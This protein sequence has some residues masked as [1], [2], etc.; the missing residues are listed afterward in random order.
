MEFVAAHGFSLSLAAPYLRAA[1]IAWSG[2]GFRL[3]RLGGIELYATDPTLLNAVAPSERETGRAPFYLFDGQFSAGD[4]YFHTLL[5]VP[6]E[7]LRRRIDALLDN[8]RADDEIDAGE[9]VIGRFDDRRLELATDPLSQYP[10]YYFR[11]GERFII[12]NVLRQIA[13]VLAASELTVTPSLLPCLEG[14][15]FG[16]V[17][18]DSTHLDEVRR[19]PFGHMV[20]A[21]PRLRFHRRQTQDRDLTYE[22]IISHG[23]SALA[24]H[25]RAVA[26]AVPRPRL[27]ATDVT[28][29]S[30]LRLV[31]SLL[32]DSPL[33]N[34]IQGRCF[35]RY[36]N[37]DANVAGALMSKYNLP[38]AQVPFVID[39]D[40]RFWRQDLQRRMIETNAA[41]TGGA[42]V[43]VAPR[44]TIAF[45]NFVHFS[46][47]F[48]EIGGAFPSVDFVGE[49]EREEYS[50]A[51]A[52][53]LI[54]AHRRQARALDLVSNEGIAVVC[55][56]AINALIALEEEGIPREHLPA[57]FYLR[58]RCRSHFGLADWQLNKSKIYPAPLAS[59][60]LVEARRRL[61]RRLHSK[62]KVILD[63]MLLGSS[64]ELA[65]LPM[66]DKIWDSSIVPVAEQEM[67]RKI[68]PV[69]ASTAPL[70]SLTGALMATT[71]EISKEVRQIMSDPEWH[72]EQKSH[73]PNSESGYQFDPVWERVFDRRR[74]GAH[75]GGPGSRSS[76]CRRLDAIEPQ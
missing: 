45:P 33:H 68:T 53:D 73:R 35:T 72:R 61:P 26:S 52:I 27:I 51:R 19:V 31:L 54:I 55:S 6:S 16:G 14:I 38:I 20:V 49:A 40:P 13:A 25:V 7:E 70:S 2:E 28:G 24:R 17:L 47:Y 1:A 56:N 22:E 63:L 64:K 62:N 75:A 46:G 32:L 43:P 41:F 74:T 11:S 66:A 71:S 76:Q 42:R 57:E 5:R 10:L 60:W 67:F 48:G 58:T 3:Q 18:G 4:R 29:G 50:A 15:V 59:T 34:E 23:R 44:A 37:P 69:T 21:D 9:F 39:V 30:D 36:P 12:S 65:L 8:D